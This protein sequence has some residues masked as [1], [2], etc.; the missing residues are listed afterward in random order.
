MSYFGDGTAK[1]DVLD[2]VEQIR[3]DQLLTYD[4][5]IACLAAVIMYYAELR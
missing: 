1:Q 4:G 3:Q 2:V 5:I